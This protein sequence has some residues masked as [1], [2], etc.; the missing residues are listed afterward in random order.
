[1]RARRFKA[2]ERAEGRRQ[3]ARSLLYVRA[4]VSHVESHVGCG[5]LSKLR[6]FSYQFRR[7]ALIKGRI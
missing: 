7:F 1:M 6:G 4:C 3:R 5:S 2:L